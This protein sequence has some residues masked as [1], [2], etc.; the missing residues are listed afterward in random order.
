MLQTFG[1]YDLQPAFPNF[2]NVWNAIILVFQTLTLENWAQV[3]GG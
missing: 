1:H 3:R 2:H